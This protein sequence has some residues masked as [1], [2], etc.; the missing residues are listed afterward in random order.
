[1]NARLFTCLTLTLLT[2]WSASSLR[3]A[4]PGDFEK[5][6]AALR[7]VGPEGAG[8]AEAAAAFQSLSAAE[9]DAILPLL[10]AMETSGPIARNWLRSAVEVIVE[11]SQKAGK[12]LPFAD[13]KAFLDDTRQSPE[14]R[15]L[16]YDLMAKIDAQAA[17]K[18]IPGFLN[19]PST[20]LR[21]DA[22][23]QLIA[24]GKA[25]AEKDDKTA[26]IATYRQ[27]LD[28][29]RDVD[30]IQ[31]IAK[32]LSE[33]LGQEVDLPRHFGFL[34]HWH[35]IA[36]FDNTG[37]EGFETVFPPEKEIKLDATYPGK[38]GKEVTWQP[39]AS[40]DE[41]GKIDFN[42]PFGPLKEVT[43]YA[44]TE[45]TAAEARPAEL[46]LA[47]KNAWKI[48]FN[49]ELIF[50]RDEYHRGQR[51]DQYKLPVQLK[52]GKNTLLV[53]A[54]QNEQTQD[55]TVEWEFKLRVC[56]ATG[57]ALLATDRPATPKKEAPKRRGGGAEESKK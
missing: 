6:V 29:A 26:A 7:A 38:E 14:A 44:Y 5:H 35:V 8:N 56:D 41:Y 1:M 19:D 28:A 16:A 36:P 25:E 49:G 45:Y 31:E 27:A 13:L 30:Q 10:R 3:A 9:A 42:Q 48:W 18:L 32:Q 22:V 43:G 15:R 55:W 34:T 40:T 23:A 37:R 53:K 24:T 12:A 21:R 57:T 47:C 54:C 52:A 46:R 17:Q 51:I 39:L 2:S 20:E 33:K 11:R 4:L 50:G